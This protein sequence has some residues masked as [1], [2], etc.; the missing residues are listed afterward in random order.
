MSAHFFEHFQQWR[1]RHFPGEYNPIL[2]HYSSEELFPNIYPEPPLAQFKAFSLCPITSCLGEE[3]DCHLSTSSF[4]V[5]VGGNLC[6]P[7][8]CECGKLQGQRAWT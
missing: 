6:V 3:A 7:V 2:N 8:Q 4:Q 1:F 5:V